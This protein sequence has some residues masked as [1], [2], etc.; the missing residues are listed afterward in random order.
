[1]PG[2]APR[3]QFQRLFRLQ[4]YL[5]AEA[6]RRSLLLERLPA[7][8]AP[9]DVRQQD[10]SRY[11]TRSFT[12]GQNRAVFT[13]SEDGRLKVSWSPNLPGPLSLSEQQH[14]NS[15]RDAIISEMVVE[16]VNHGG[17]AMAHCRATWQAES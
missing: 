8:G 17:I 12:I 4:K 7:S 2:K 13:L 14:Y 11:M 16:L 6:Q 10:R 1:M 15:G 9:G 3:H 5:H